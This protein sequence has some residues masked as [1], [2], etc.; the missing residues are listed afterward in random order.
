MANI[1]E[2]NKKLTQ[3]KKNRSDYEEDALYREVW[4]DVNNEKTTAF[5]KKYYRVLVAGALAILIVVVG[6]QIV[7]HN[8]QQNIIATSMQYETAIENM[9]S[10]ALAAMAAGSKSATSDLALYQSYMLDGDITKLENLA[11]NGKTRDF[12]DLAKM[13]LAGA[14]GDAMTAA[15][16]EKFMSSLVTKKS[17]YYYNAMLLIGQK[18]LSEGDHKNA[19]KWLDKIINDENAPSVISGTAETLR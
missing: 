4:E 17:P 8:R 3:Q 5:L 1:L 16:F 9:D 7:R 15:E 2:R 12:R 19:N 13:H 11:K 18:Y 10:R 14:N 6:I